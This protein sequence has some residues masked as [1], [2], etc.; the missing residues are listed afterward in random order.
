M[1]VDGAC[2]DED[3]YKFERG[4]DDADERDTVRC[5]NTQQ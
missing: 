1:D 2:K 3:E 4:G 5:L